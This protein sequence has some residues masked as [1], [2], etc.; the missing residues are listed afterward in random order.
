MEFNFSR[1]LG[2]ELFL[3][4]VKYL[5]FVPKSEQTYHTRTLK[6]INTNYVTN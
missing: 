3:L 2:T 6:N 1:A 4:D 5:E